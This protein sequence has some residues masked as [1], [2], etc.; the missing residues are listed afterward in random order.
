MMAQDKKE[1]IEEELIFGARKR[2][3]FWRKLAL[4]GWGFG[5]V[6]CLSAA[7][8]A[9]L[10]E[11]PAPAL[12]PFDPTTGMALPMASVGTISLNEQQAVVQSL[13]F[14]YVRDREV[15]NRLDNDQRVQTL[16]NR[17]EGSAR[18]SLVE[19]WTADNPNYPPKLYGEQARMDVEVISVTPISNDRA[20]ARIVKRLT[21]PQGTTEGTFTV[22][23]AYSFQPQDQRTLEALWQNPFG[24]S[25]REYVVSSERFQQ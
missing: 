13:V 4:T 12:V 15:Y 18:R 8:V 21:T 14:T 3:V 25:V 20:T 19:Q 24:F 23:L 5:I 11:K 22:S 1:I 17:S 16:L 6:G 2:E 10:T 9:V 7:A